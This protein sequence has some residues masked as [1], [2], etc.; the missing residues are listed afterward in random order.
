MATTIESIIE[1]PP[2]PEGSGFTQEQWADT[3]TSIWVQWWKIFYYQHRDEID[4]SLQAFTEKVFNQLQSYVDS[5]EGVQEA[6]KNP[7]PAPAG[8]TSIVEIPE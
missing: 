2:N 1:I 6:A 4:T 7:Q 3:M 8:T 5:L